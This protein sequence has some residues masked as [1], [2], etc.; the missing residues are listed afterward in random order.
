MLVAVDTFEVMFLKSL[1]K[2]PK[3]KC[4]SM[5]VNCWNYNKGSFTQIQQTQSNT[6]KSQSWHICFFSLATSYGNPPKRK[7]NLKLRSFAGPV[8]D[9]HCFPTDMHETLH[10]TFGLADSLKGQMGPPG[11]SCQ[12]SFCLNLTTTN[13][14]W[15]KPW[16]IEVWSPKKGF[17]LIFFN[18]PF[19][20]AWELGGRIGLRW[21]HTCCD[22][23]L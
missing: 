11:V 8:T 16:K 19:V 17:W 23:Q 15:K 6:L 12:I 13:R 3:E 10:L 7:K 20:S 21:I 22:W 5:M 18:H 14:P 2:A 9:G 4:L 1:V